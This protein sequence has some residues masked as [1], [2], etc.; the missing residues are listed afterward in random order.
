M[1]EQSTDLMRLR[2]VTF[3]YRSEYDDGNGLQQY[4]LVAEE[5]AEV[6]PDLVQYEETGEPSAV[7]YHFVNAMLL[8]EVQRQHRQIAT[9]TARLAKLEALVGTQTGR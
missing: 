3:Q 5:V 8:N 9:L 6:F 1:G 4:G 7:R 2:P